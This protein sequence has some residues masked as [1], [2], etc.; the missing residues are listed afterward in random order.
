MSNFVF[1]CLLNLVALIFMFRDPNFLNGTYVYTVST[2]VQII[3][4]ILAT[5]WCNGTSRYGSDDEGSRRPEVT[6]IQ[7]AFSS[8]ETGEAS[9]TESI[10]SRDS[11]SLQDKC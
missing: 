3:G 4:V 7:F 8:R 1:P 6:S 11:E 5:I 10:G 9:L 2:Y